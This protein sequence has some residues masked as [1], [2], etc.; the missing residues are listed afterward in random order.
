MKQLSKLKMLYGI[1]TIAS[2]MGLLASFLQMIE[3]ITLLENPHA[4]L[5]CNIN[6]VFSCTNILN[7]WQSSVFGFPNS[8]MCT[9]FFSLTMAIGLVGWTGGSIN[10]RLRLVFMGLSL[11]FIGFGFWY[12]WQSI[13]IV[14][15]LCVYCM[16]CYAAV[17]VISSA[18]VRLNS[19]DMNLNKQSQ[20]YLDRMI[21]SGY[22]LIIWTL[23]AVII[24]AEVLI[25]FR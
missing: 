10:S 11:F 16:A 12:L 23:I 8:L 4:V 1:I 17:L 2:I 24:I 7:V 6:S 22:D 21:V 9:V 15:A 19:K 20:K 3:K 25:K 13:F 14:G 5:T 18:W